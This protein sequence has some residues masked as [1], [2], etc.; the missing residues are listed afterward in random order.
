[1][2]DEQ[3]DPEEAGKR[4]SS[5]WKRIEEPESLPGGRSSAA[6]RRVGARRIYTAEE[7]SA[8]LE[9][10]RR[11][12]QGVEDFAAEHGVHASTLYMWRYR[13]R[14]GLDQPGAR[15]RSARIFSP[16]E[17]RSAL[18][19]WSKSGL[20]SIAFAKLWGV[21][22]ESLRGWRA[23]YELGGPRA[24]E[25]KPV[26]RPRGDGRSTL[27]APLQA[28][29][30]RTKRRF[31]FFGLKKV[32]DFLKRFQG[33]HV[34]AGSVRKVLASEGLH[35]PSPKPRQKKHPVVRRFERSKPGELW[36]TDITSYVLTR[37]RVR[38]YLTVF[39]DDFSRYVV[40]FALA[41]HQKSQLVCEALMEGIERF[42]KPEEVLSDQGRQY[43][44]WRGKS[45]F[46]RLL[47]REGIQHVV[48]RTHHPETLGK[49]ERLWE[50]VGT[51]LWERVQPQELGEARERLAHYFAHYNHFRPHQGIGGL[52]PADRFFGAE[53]ALR[54][55]LEARMEHDELGAALS[56]TP[57]KGV[58]VFGQV[59]DQQVSL[60]G[61][62][63]RIVLVTSDGVSKE[64]ALEDLGLPQTEKSH[65][66]SDG[67]D[68]RDGLGAAQAAGQEAA[69]LPAAEER[70][71]LG[72]SAVGRGESGGA[73]AGARDV[74][75]D[76]VDVA[77]PQVPRAGGERALGAA[78]AGL[79][80]Q[81]VGALGYARGP[82]QTA[83][84]AEEGLEHGAERG[85]SA[86]LEEEDRGA[87]G[88]EPLAARPGGG[89]EEPPGRQGTARATP[90]AETGGEEGCKEDRKDRGTAWS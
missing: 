51:E 74:R 49:C 53:D 36:Q 78:A 32:R 73:D 65:E 6:E 28:E 15:T 27:P 55:S 8:L 19:A 24:L 21:S 75:V 64:L 82:S 52:V 57:R 47:V 25:P 17:R 83:P 56:R 44:A 70:A 61:E 62:R 48:S 85:G 79:A 20:P 14:H 11:S 30:V 37:S 60:H 35:D 58:Y 39:L 13:A 59:G 31:P 77:G 40:S 67:A 71:E 89:A 3:G 12:G 26:G 46:Q 87:G 10:L 41:T 9:A 43:F 84:G 18:E 81:P 54:K 90:P 72:A 66:R 86:R 63:G 2:A 38:V 88:G 4:L 22:A 34:S 1:M 29:I 45:D 16:E 7:R 68:Q 33:E 76:P 5:P 69:G 23:R 80:A 42:G 50:T